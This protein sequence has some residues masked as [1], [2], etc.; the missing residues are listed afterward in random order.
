M[1]SNLIMFL[2]NYIMH[3]KICKYFLIHNL[4]KYLLI[5]YKCMI[6]YT[7]IELINIFSIPVMSIQS[8]QIIY[9]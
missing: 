1:F 6:H 4:Y 3:F 7:I 5:K 9:S 2:Y 8:K